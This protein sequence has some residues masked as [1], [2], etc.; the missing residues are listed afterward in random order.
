MSDTNTIEVS[1]FNLHKY[2]EKVAGDSFLLNKAPDGRIVAT[3]A[4]GLGS[5]VK[6][7]VLSQITA[8]M[9]QKF[10]FSNIDVG[11]VANAVLETLP[12]CSVRKVSYST[13]TTINI[14]DDGLTKLLEYDNP[15][16]LW[17]RG[18]E[19]LPVKKTL[20]KVKSNTVRNKTFYS[21]IKL[22][23]GDRLIFFSDGVT[24]AGM[25][26]ED[27][28]FGWRMDNVKEYINHTVQNNS[29]ISANELSRIIVEK[30]KL[31]DNSQPKDD[32]T[33]AVVY[34]RK[35]RD[36]LL[37]AGP[38]GDREQCPYLVQKFQEFSGKKI[39][40][41]GTTSQIIA[42]GIGADI[43][44]DMTDLNSDIPPRSKMQE[45][46]LVTEGLLTIN[47]VIKVLEAGEVND[48]TD[49]DAACRM[50]Q[51]LL[52]S[53]HIYFLVGTAINIAHQSQNM[54]VEMGLRR[55]SMNKLASVLREKHLK[56]VT[57]E[58]V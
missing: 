45:A 3:L 25:G 41:G 37:L 17:L 2:N 39:V 52:D 29:N 55:I 12:V 33:C 30:S 7:N 48:I 54:P 24:Q 34:Y 21:E 42:S 27:T 47:K 13:F 44:V 19:F 56:K 28:P 43:E 38:P 46:D 11:R 51:L 35:T 26:M 23:F 14:S 20:F 18:D 49:V 15:E 31:L 9:L 8:S 6:A 22:E 32:I 10:M 4:D 57:V 58:Y 5:G 53:D 36:T 16:L 50:A 1:Y 40:S